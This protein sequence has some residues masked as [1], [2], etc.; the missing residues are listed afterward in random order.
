VIKSCNHKPP[1]AHLLLFRRSAALRLTSLAR[2]RSHLH[3][4]IRVRDG[5][6]SAPLSPMPCGTTRASVSNLTRGG[7]T[8]GDDGAAKSAPPLPM[9]SGQ[10]RTRPT[11]VRMKWKPHNFYLHIPPYSCSTIY[12]QSLQHI[13]R[14]DITLKLSTKIRVL[15]KIKD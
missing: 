15:L 2:L 1:R 9:L 8:S 7:S 5:A 10:C 13:F 11:E 6:S 3:G 14:N 12:G 4:C